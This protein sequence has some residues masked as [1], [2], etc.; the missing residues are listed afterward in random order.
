MET[1]KTIYFFCVFSNFCLAIFITHTKHIAQ[2][3][4]GND[5]NLRQGYLDETKEGKYES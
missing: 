2:S 4:N 5:D 3:N 1:Q